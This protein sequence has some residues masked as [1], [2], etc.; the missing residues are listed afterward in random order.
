MTRVSIVVIR[1]DDIITRLSGIISG[2]SSEVMAR[3]TSL[4][5][6]LNRG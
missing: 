4:I 1:L 5:P 2:L 6:L 3:L